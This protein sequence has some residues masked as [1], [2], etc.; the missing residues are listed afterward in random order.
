VENE[1]IRQSEQAWRKMHYVNAAGSVG[2]EPAG[3]SYLIVLKDLKNKL[4][5]QANHERKEQRSFSLAVMGK[6]KDFKG[7][8]LRVWYL[9]P[10]RKSLP[11]SPSPCPS[12]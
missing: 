11:R 2:D 12:D 5:A 3:I 1:R 10:L 8:L 4:D 7:K 6:L 9:L